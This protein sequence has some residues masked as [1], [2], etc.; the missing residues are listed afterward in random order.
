MLLSVTRIRNSNL[1]F[2]KCKYPVLMHFA[3]DGSTRRK[4]MY[5]K[6]RP[7]EW[8]ITAACK[9]GPAYVRSHSL[10][11]ELQRAQ[12]RRRAEVPF[13]LLFFYLAE[14]RKS[15]TLNAVLGIFCVACV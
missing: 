5:A 7:D 3:L 11:R 1:F 10:A 13:K 4:I 6:R 14:E 2:A 12:E 15:K 8:A 9:Y